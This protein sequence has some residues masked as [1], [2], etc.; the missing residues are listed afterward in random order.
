MSWEEVLPAELTLRMDSKILVGGVGAERPATLEIQ[1]I[2]DSVKPA[3]EAQSGVN[4]TEFNVIKYASQVVAGTNYYM[5]V[6]LGGDKYCHL[7]IYDPL[8]FTGEPPRLD[9]YQ[10]EKTEKDPI[11]PF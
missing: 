10:L 6:C 3:F 8:P 5:K 1:I 7:R 4:A 11:T 9:G 2:C